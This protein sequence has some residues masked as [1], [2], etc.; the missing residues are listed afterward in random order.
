MN[1]GNLNV[2]FGFKLLARFGMD[3]KNMKARIKGRHH[4]AAIAMLL[5]STLFLVACGA[6]ST[7]QGESNANQVTKT[8]PNAAG[9]SLSV[10][11]Y[12][13]LLATLEA[14]NKALKQQLGSVAV[15]GAGATEA[16]PSYTAPDPELYRENKELKARNEGLNTR[17]QTENV[18]RLVAEKDLK[19]LK[20]QLQACRQQNSESGRKYQ[21]LSDSLTDMQNRFNEAQTALRQCKP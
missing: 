1:W 8:A 5:S 16:A 12:Q 21:A 6:D 20:D 4:A 13:E 19:L 3:E 11:Q 10:A 17:F 18:A 7:Q 15:A 2:I 14:E 9:P